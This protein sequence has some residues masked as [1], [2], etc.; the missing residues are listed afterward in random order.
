MNLEE[1]RAQFPL[2][3]QKINGYPLVYLDNAASSQKPDS[4][5]NCIASYYREINA[6]V[7][8]GI[9]TLSQ[10]ATVKMEQS[11]EKVR[12]FIGAK[13]EKE[14]IFT[15]GTSHSIN[16]LAHSFGSFIAK[17]DEIIVSH[18]E[19][20]S[21]IVPWQMLCQRTGAI[22]KVIPID[23]QGALDMDV[24]Q[25]LLSSQTK[26][27]AV[28]H[29]SNA[30]GVINPIQEI[31]QKAHGVGAK[32]MIDGAQAV[33]HLPIDVTGLDVDF[34]VF[35]AHKMYG[36]TGVGILYGK[37]ELLEQMPPFMG[38][39]E[40]IR[41]VRFEG[42]TYADLPFKFEPGTPNIAG[43]I[44]LGAAIDF[45]NSLGVENIQ[46]HEKKLMAYAKEKLIQIENLTV[47]A[48]DLDT[49]GAISFN[50]NLPGVHPSDLGMILDKQGIAIRTG[51][52]CTQPIMSRLGVLGT[53]R[54]S[55][56]VYNTFEEIDLLVKGIEK[57]KQLLL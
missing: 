34:Y 2:L 35:S 55:F 41:E 14:I 32:V 6:N 57:A 30:L 22:L 38:G 3:H 13:S 16:L 1:I 12:D 8:R 15:S 19:H 17:G 28:N 36:P 37:Q 53:A 31:I 40:M 25:S 50:L 7:H 26:L 42:S 23:D 20:H 10:E 18:L 39:G 47:Y 44:A 27:V 51:H 56:C 49:A 33:P 52:H 24:F 46:N 54:A 4:V 48:L 21:N 43:N 45:M 11:R 5:I 9:H 29:I